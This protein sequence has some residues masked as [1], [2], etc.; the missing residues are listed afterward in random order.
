[1]HERDIPDRTFEFV[2]NLSNDELRI[3]GADLSP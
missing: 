1:V 3:S 2:F